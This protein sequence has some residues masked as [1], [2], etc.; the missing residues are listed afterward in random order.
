MTETERFSFMR[1]HG[2]KVSFWRTKTIGMQLVR[3]KDIPSLALKNNGE[4][5]K[6]GYYVV[7]YDTKPHGIRGETNTLLATVWLSCLL[8]IYRLEPGTYDKGRVFT[9]PFTFQ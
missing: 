8:L 4:V 1:F 6:V 9:V 3:N 5:G 7:L 2:S